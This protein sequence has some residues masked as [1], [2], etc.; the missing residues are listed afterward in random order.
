MRSL[1]SRSSLGNAEQLFNVHSFV[2]LLWHFAFLWGLDTFGTFG[3][4]FDIL[5]TRGIP[6]VTSSLLYC[7]LKVTS[8][9]GFTLKG[10]NLLPRGANS[11]LIVDPFPEGSPIF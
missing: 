9:K 2:R 7:A 8:E 6:F 4:F 3:T 1:F 5:F 10:K 11:Y